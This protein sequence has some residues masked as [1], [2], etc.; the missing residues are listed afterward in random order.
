MYLMSNAH[1]VTELAFSTT[2]IAVILTYI[3]TN[4]WHREKQSI[5][6]TKV[7]NKAALVSAYNYKKSI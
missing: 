5:K 7:Q 1:R 4:S 6:N 2:E 3:T